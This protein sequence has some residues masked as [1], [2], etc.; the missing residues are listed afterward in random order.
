MENNLKVQ[1]SDKFAVQNA[2]SLSLFLY[3]SSL[4]I[5]ARDKNQS[6]TEIHSYEQISWKKLDEVLASDSLTKLDVP[7]KVYIHEELF[8]LLPGVFFQQ[9]NEKEYLKL[10]GELPA[11]PYF[12]H[13]TVDSN[14]LQ[15]LS[16]IPEK[17][18]QQ[19]RK[20]FSE[21]SFYHGSCS[22]LS[23]L[24]KERF[25]LIGQE[26]WI[27]LFDSH[28]YVA[29]FT[30]QELSVFNRFEVTTKEDVL[31][32][33]L[34][35]MESLQHDRNHARVT[36]F[37]ATEKSGITEDWG[38]SYFANFRLRRPHTNQ[39]YGTGLSQDKAPIIF[40]SFWHYL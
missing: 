32:Y 3:A 18:E 36:L 4:H 11:T 26:I 40:E 6:I 24:F 13:T 38:K 27:N 10:T 5:F 25:N 37:G 7:A 22:F 8:T 1:T 30:D 39:N 20:R 19:L 17:L 12:F 23:Y 9:G 15:I 33:A 2:A 34:I 29:A 28:A 21:L 16:C 31:K 35:L 14:N